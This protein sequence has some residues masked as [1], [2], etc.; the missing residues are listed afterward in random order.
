MKLLLTKTL[1]QRL[2]K[3]LGSQTWQNLYAEVDGQ[4][5]DITENGMNSCAV[6]V[7]AML[8]GL[9]DGLLKAPHAG[10]DGL[11]RDLID[12]GWQTLETVREGAVL[13]WKLRGGK[14]AK[15]HRHAGFYIGNGQSISNDSRGSGMP[16]KHD[17]EYRKEGPEYGPRE[18][19]QIY[20][21]DKLND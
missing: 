15:M 14:D 5:K 21:H 16:W 2:T 6:F 8:L 7:S 13:I 19:E 3:S 20:W 17:F 4:A 1:L 18:I 11:E 9:S 10:V 12:S